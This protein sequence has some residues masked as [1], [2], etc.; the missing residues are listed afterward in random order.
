VSGTVSGGPLS[1][2]VALVTGAGRGF[3]RA[4]A[5]AY[6]AAGADVVLHYR[7]SKDGC[8]EVAE[9]AG[10]LG[11]RAVAVPA[12]LADAG[13]IERLVT[14][15]RAEF[16]FVDVLVNNAGSMR[17]GGF[18]DST[19]ADW[20]AD[21]DVNVWAPLR[22]THAVAPMMVARGYGKIVNVS[23][24]LALRGW[25]RGAVYAGTKGFLLSWTRSMAVELGPHGITVNA[26]GPGSIVTDM[27]REIFPDDDAIRRKAAELPLRRM[28]APSDVA[29]CAVFL[30][31]PGSDFVTGQFVGVNGGSQM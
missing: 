12:D 6:V 21:L 29:E 13:A 16:G 24:Q 9:Q 17:V 8:A 1:G 25:G 28:G 4:I 2:R 19:E 11:R 5:E 27:N 20:A 31:G 18:L 30:A 15:A 26:I 10:A 7:T 23:S 14:A 22:L 3:G